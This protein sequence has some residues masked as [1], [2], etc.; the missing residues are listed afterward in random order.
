MT[1]PL[2]AI[3]NLVKT[4]SV[5]STEKKANSN[6]D[7]AQPT[8][9]S[10]SLAQ[11]KS[12]GRPFQAK[13]ERMSSSKNIKTLV[14]NLGAQ[15]KEARKQENLVLTKRA[16]VQKMGG[17]LNSLRTDKKYAGNEQKLNKA[18]ENA[19]HQ[20]KLAGKI[21]S[22]Q[23]AYLLAEFE[24]N[25]HTELM[26]KPQ[27]KKAADEL[28]TKIVDFKQNTSANKMGSGQSTIFSAL[29]ESNQPLEVVKAALTG[30]HQAG[31]I[32][33][34]EKVMLDGLLQDYQPSTQEISVNQ[35]NQPKMLSKL[36]KKYSLKKRRLK[37]LRKATNS[38]VYCL[39]KIVVMNY[40]TSWMNSYVKVQIL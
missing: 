2:K 9:R 34:D 23:Q 25:S 35:K 32:N 4:K 28:I 11:A 7:V 40:K 20:A 30:L 15:Q 29:Q 26:L 38:S 13:M 19:L 24:A 6:I 12:T 21:D 22:E 8:K 18:V 10:G 5:N 39:R 16:A 37:R 36:L 3:T 27:E 31:V 14:K 33:N 17:L 1:N